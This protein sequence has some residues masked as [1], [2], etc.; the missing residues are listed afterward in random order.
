MKISTR[1][2]STFFFLFLSVVEVAAAWNFGFVFDNLLFAIGLHAPNCSNQR[3][4]ILPKI[5]NVACSVEE[6]RRTLEQTDDD[7]DKEEDTDASGQNSR[8]NAEYSGGPKLKHCLN[9]VCP[10]D[11][12]SSDSSGS[13]QQDYESFNYDSEN[14]ESES[15]EY[16]ANDLDYSD[17][18][19]IGGNSIS[20]G[21]DQTTKFSLLSFLIAAAVATILLGLFILKKRRDEQDS[22]AKEELLAEDSFHGSIAK[23]ISRARSG[24]RVQ[25]LNLDVAEKG[26]TETN[27]VNTTGYAL[28]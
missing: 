23:R 13:A 14:Y 18:S 8:C 24:K 5:C 22:K 21:T 1:L 15:N 27:F 25:A 11:G 7:K 3:G 6:S 17:N 4:P 9:I 12:S 2:C 26:G 28:A 16:S 20:T 19:N 10:S